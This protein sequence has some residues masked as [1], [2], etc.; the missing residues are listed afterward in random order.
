MTDIP[1][2][3]LVWFPLRPN[4]SSKFRFDFDQFLIY[5]ILVFNLN[6]LSNVQF[7]ILFYFYL[8]YFIL[9]ILFLFLFWKIYAGAGHKFRYTSEIFAPTALRLLGDLSIA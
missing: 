2:T 8:L 9:F 6:L 5:F 4:C 3:E 1:A 7:N